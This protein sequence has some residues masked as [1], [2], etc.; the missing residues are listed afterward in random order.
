MVTV[1]KSCETVRDGRKHTTGTVHDVRA[2]RP[3]E[4]PSI[5]VTP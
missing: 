3:W 5:P 4:P 1:W 2:S